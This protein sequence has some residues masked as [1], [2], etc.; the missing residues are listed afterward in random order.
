MKFMFILL[1]EIFSN[2]IVNDMKGE[3]INSISFPTI[4][5]PNISI[6]FLLRHADIFDVAVDDIIVNNK[7]PDI[8]KTVYSF[9]LDGNKFEI[10]ELTKDISANKHSLYEIDGV[11]YLG[12]KKYPYLVIIK[13]I[14]NIESL[15]ENI[16]MVNAYLEEA[17]LMK[18]RLIFE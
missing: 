18:I 3:M 16:D 17:G 12:L 1:I 9:T 13:E 15:F 5:E 8:S 11:N 10:L 2:L 7:Y 6:S 4:K 14:Y